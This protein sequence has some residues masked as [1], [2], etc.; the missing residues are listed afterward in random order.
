MNFLAKGPWRAMAAIPASIVNKT[1]LTCMGNKAVYKK[2]QGPPLVKS[3]IV[4]QQSTTTQFT[5][6]FNRSLRSKAMGDISV[7]C[8]TDSFKA[9]IF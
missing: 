3:Y 4:K 1:A 2:E 6:C 7:V 9:K 5:C 8:C